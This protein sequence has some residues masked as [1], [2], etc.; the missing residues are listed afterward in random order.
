MERTIVSS[1]NIYSIGYDAYSNTL[2][3]QFHTGSIY[4][5][6]NVPQSV[7]NG[8]ISASSHGSYLHSYVKGSYQYKRMG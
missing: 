8:L 2:E 1:S 5:Y 4:Q 6:Y 7:Y 3:V